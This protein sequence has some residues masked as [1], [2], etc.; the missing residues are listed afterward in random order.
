MCI[1]NSEFSCNLS[2]ILSSVS[3]TFLILVILFSISYAQAILI[4]SLTISFLIF[5]RLSDDDDIIKRLNQTENDEE[6]SSD[7]FFKFQNSENN[8]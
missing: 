7:S 1:L 8:I 5:K 6:N 4:V 2:V 3:S